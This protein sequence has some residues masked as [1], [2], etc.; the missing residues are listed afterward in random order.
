M[1]SE[2]PG[3][4]ADVSSR[5]TGSDQG[6]RPL[7]SIVTVTRNCEAT[8]ERTLA[9][10]RRIKTPAI[11]YIVIDGAST[12]STPAILA[13][14]DDIVDILVSERDSGIYNAM[15]KGAALASGDYTLFLNGDDHLLPEG[16]SQAVALLGRRRPE[17]LSCRSGAVSETG[18][19]LGL[20]ELSA[21]RLFFFNTV[22]HLSTFVR[23]DLQKKYR[24][25]EQF[26]IAADYD[27]FLR[28]FLRRHRFSTS[29]LITATHY[30]GGF[31]GNVSLTIQECRQIRRENLGWMLYTLTR[32]LEVG[33][34][35]LNSVLRRGRHTGSSSS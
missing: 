15:N 25:R 35:I 23:S 10:V 20:L 1:P 30:R 26:K 33:N 5:M 28:L 29:E 4:P 16:F 6:S 18:E 2:V 34:E 17:L 14:Y 3:S 27:L 21:W 22:P 8:L 9:S 13:R 24:F 7:L 32:A 31:S 11:Q 12:D 19:P